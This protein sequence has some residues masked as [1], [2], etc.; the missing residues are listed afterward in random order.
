[1]TTYKITGIEIKH[2]H[3]I[4]YYVYTDHGVALTFT[5]Y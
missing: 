1:M 3:I 2:K 4:L 5:T